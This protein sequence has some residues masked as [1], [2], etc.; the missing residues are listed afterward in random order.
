MAEKT[1]KTNAARLLD[2]ARIPYNLIAYP[3]DEKHLD[4]VHVAESIG[5]DINQVYKTLVMRNGKSLFVCVIPGNAEVDFKK[6]A[7]VVNAKKVEMIH[8]RELLPLTGYIR[9]GCS[10]IGMKQKL[11]TYIHEDVLKLEVVYVS[12]G[13]RGLQL[14]INP[15]DLISYT[16][17]TIA[18]L[19]NNS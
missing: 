12:A 1:H 2:K 15:T 18:D 3:V 5:E 13:Q 14:Q 6:T 16:G 11:P 19:T 7:A 17:A 4:A 10:P 9:G 8:V